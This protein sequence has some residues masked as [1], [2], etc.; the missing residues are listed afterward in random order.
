[1]AGSRTSRTPARWSHSSVHAGRVASRR[2]ARPAS[3]IRVQVGR[4]LLGAVVLVWRSG[5]LNSKHRGRGVASRRCVARRHRSCARLWLSVPAVGTPT[6]TVEDRAQPR[7]SR[8]SVIGSRSV[9]ALC[10]GGA[11]ADRRLGRASWRTRSDAP[12]RPRGGVRDGPQR[13]ESIAYDLPHSPWPAP[14]P[15]CLLFEE[16]GAGQRGRCHAS[17]VPSVGGVVTRRCRTTFSDHA[18]RHL[19]HIIT[20]TNTGDDAAPRF[21]FVA[22]ARLRVDPGG[23]PRRCTRTNDSRH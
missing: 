17:D 10:T 21:L 22:P 8:S 11:P 18:G 13:P 4:A 15:R 23:A 6:V 16:H 20:T 14:P 7:P 1:M 2:G 12:A 19:R 3:F 9:A 5:V